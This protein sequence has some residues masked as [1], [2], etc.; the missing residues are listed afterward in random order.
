MIDKLHAPRSENLW[1]VS[2]RNKLQKRARIL[3]FHGRPRQRSSHC[4]LDGGEGGIRTHV[5]LR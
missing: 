5:T 2:T 4:R 1:F 3:A